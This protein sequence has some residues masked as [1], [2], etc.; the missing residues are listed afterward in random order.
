MTRRAH[1]LPLVLASLS[2]FLTPVV[3]LATDT[4]YVANYANNRIFKVDFTAGTTTQINT[5]ANQVKKLSA[6]FV[7][8]DGFD[9]IIICDTAASQV[10]IYENVGSPG[11]DGKSRPV[12]DV[13]NPDGISADE[14]GNLYVISSK[15]GR[16]K[17]RQLWFI[18]KGGPNPGGYFDARL[19]TDI[20]A[21]LLEDTKVVKVT[22]PGGLTAGDILVLSRQPARVLRFRRNG[23]R[24]TVVN[25]PT[26]PF[27]AFPGGVEPMGL[28]FSASENS[29]ELLV[30]TLDGSVLRYDFS[31]GP[32]EASFLPEGLGNGPFK[33]AT[34]LQGAHNRAFITQRNGHTVYAFDILPDG[35]A[36]PETVASVSQ[37]LNFP[38]GVGIG[39]GNGAFIPKVAQ[40]TAAFQAHT[41]TVYGGRQ[42]GIIDSN[43]RFLIKDPRE[44]ATHLACERACDEECDGKFCPRS[45][46]LNELDST[47]APA[48]IPSYMRFFRFD[49][50]DEGDAL[51]FLCTAKSSA[52]FNF[53]SI[54]FEADQV[55]NW[56]GSGPACDEGPS[57]KRA[58]FAWTPIP[59]T[60]E[61]R[62]YEDKKFINVSAGCG[63][64]RGD[65]DDY[66]YYLPFLRDT[67]PLP[68][69]GE[70]MIVGI[71]GTLDCLS[72]SIDD[73]V[74]T[75][76]RQKI[77]QAA[78]GLNRF[79]LCGDPSGKTL[80][81]QK[82]GEFQG[83]VAKNGDAF[84]DCARN[85]SGE[86][87]VRAT[88]AV[89][90]I[91]N[92][93]PPSESELDP[94]CSDTCPGPPEP[95]ECPF[96]TVTCPF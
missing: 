61:P 34:G 45:L 11:F 54:F 23:S 33:I 52:K 48:E 79:K 18:E 46:F 10:L 76:L 91:T 30:L 14:S 83:I 53:T 86:L 7:R 59:E 70:S 27:I 71:R 29:L 21:D 68:D 62:I 78:G 65:I 20:A 56:G 32:I 24:W 60:T 88:S 81:L 87:G 2:F 94:C 4:V 3:G 38:Q 58:M 69:I 1:V 42:A 41:A 31:G 9:D 25:G 73:S 92:A 50:P 66:S 57:K 95:G 93:H 47:L 84:D 80:A 19:V 75:S 8:N 13:P 89:W 17:K 82:L 96:N 40:V 63:S 26:N 74:E 72:Q 37:G 90:I 12:T 16:N 85:V 49:G 77:T 55:L 36:D 39:T 51:P 64:N 43:C 28:A 6:M 35:S 15:P 22:Q 67:R 5:D 44:F